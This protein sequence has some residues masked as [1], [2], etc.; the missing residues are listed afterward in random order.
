MRGSSSTHSFVGS[1]F[2]VVVAFLPLLLFFFSLGVEGADFTTDY[3]QMVSNLELDPDNHRLQHGLPQA[4]GREH[5]SA[6]D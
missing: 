2:F 5:K 3:S 4:L 6:R 1:S